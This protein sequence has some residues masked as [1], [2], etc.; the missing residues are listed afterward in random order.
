MVWIPAGQFNISST[1]NIASGKQVNIQGAGKF[2]SILYGTGFGSDVP[3]ISY[4]GTGAGSASIDSI[5]CR[6][7][8]IWSNN[9]LARGI[10]ASWTTNSAF[11]D[12]YFYDCYN[13]WVGYTAFGN[14]FRNNNAYNIT[15]ASYILSTYA[16]ANAGCSNSLFEGVRMVGNVG[17]AVNTATDSLAFIGCDIEGIIGNGA[18]LA[19]V[20]PTGCVVSNVVVMGS[21]IENINGTAIYCAGVD[22]NS[23]TGLVVKGNIIKGGFGDSANPYAVNAIQLYHVNGFDISGNNFI[24]WGTDDATGGG[25]QGYACYYMSTA[26]NGVIENN[27]S[28]QSTIGGT[29]KRTVQNLCDVLPAASVR[30]ANNWAPVNGTGYLGYTVNYTNS[31]EVTLPYSS[32]IAV[33]AST[34]GLFDITATNNTGFT[35]SNPTNG[36]K[37]KTITF[38]IRNTSGGAL[39][40]VTWMSSF[41]MSTWTSPA[42]AYSRSVTFC[43]DGTYWIQISQTGVDVPN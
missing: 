10:T 9:N 27:T 37:G 4:N 41:K 12:L 1:L 17:C 6:G 15:N 13:G 38:K 20:P 11:D 14:K 26:S 16:G 2:L 7:F 33:D 43:F 39:G 35:I 29:V 30:I 18:G 3:V 34:G 42:N 21:H 36:F 5:G 28:A 40:A 32:T 31:N 8:A 24:D 23:V 25:T 22:A 19:L